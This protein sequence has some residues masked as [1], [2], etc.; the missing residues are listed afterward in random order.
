MI[1]AVGVDAGGGKHPLG[2]VEGA[3][4]NAATVQAL[5]D[6]LIDR[7]LIPHCAGPSSS[8]ARSR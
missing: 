6:T 7:D 2:V 8:A 5:L 1:G 3:T 4:E